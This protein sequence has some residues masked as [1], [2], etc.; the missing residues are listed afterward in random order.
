MK[1]QQVWLLTTNVRS[2]RPSKKLDYKRLGPFKISEV[3]NLVTYRLKL[4]KKMRIHPV[5][6]VSLLEPYHKNTMEGRIPPPPP[7]IGE[8]TDEGDERE[9]EVEGILDSRLYYRKLQYLVTWK[10]FLKK[11]D[12]WE[13]AEGVKHCQALIRQFHHDHPFRPGPEP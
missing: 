9:W 1:G 8:I 2:Q 13:P 5:F 4:P 10:G 12:S 11:D 3:V 6:H 7:P